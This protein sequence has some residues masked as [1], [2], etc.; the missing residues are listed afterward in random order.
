MANGLSGKAKGDGDARPTGMPTPSCWSSRRLI[1]SG[2][3]R[4]NQ[5]AEW[6]RT[7]ALRAWLGTGTTTTTM[8]V[9][10]KSVGARLPPSANWRERVTSSRTGA[11]G[12]PCHRRQ[13]PGAYLIAK[14]TASGSTIEAVL[15]QTCRQS[16]PGMMRRMNSSKSGAVNVVFSW[17][18]PP[19]TPLAIG[20][21]HVNSRAVNLRPSPAAIPRQ[22][23]GPWP[24]RATARRYL[25]PA[26]IHRRRTFSTSTPSRDRMWSSAF[27][28][29]TN[30]ITLRQQRLNQ[31]AVSW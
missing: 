18:G 14:E 27:C 31:R 24:S 12:G 21:S 1:S 16:S 25:F 17:F 9:P 29:A 11:S 15:L 28:S 6:C 13:L 4:N 3:C 26:G 7:P 5:D 22:R 8:S 23:C 19:I 20:W 30:G 10:P 2:R